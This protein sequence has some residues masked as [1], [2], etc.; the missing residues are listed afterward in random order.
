MLG[1]AVR[2]SPSCCFEATLLCC[3]SLL[4]LGTCV[5]PA[6]NGTCQWPTSQLTL[7]L[8]DRTWGNMACHSSQEFS[9]CSSCTLD[10]GIGMH[11]GLVT[12]SRGGTRSTP[13]RR[14][15]RHCTFNV[16]QGATCLRARER[17]ATTTP[18]PTP[19]DKSTEIPRV[20]ARSQTSCKTL[21]RNKDAHALYAA[22]L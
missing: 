14:R 4:H 2:V 6:N 13:Y 1:L 20:T 7:S 8:H 21:T 16:S 10:G 11:R 22:H 15:Q 18:T 12:L 19:L 9:A 3:S 17:H 5:N